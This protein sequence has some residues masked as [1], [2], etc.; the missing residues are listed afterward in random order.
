[1]SYE[2]W[3]WYFWLEM[4]QPGGDEPS[5]CGLGVSQ[6]LRSGISLPPGSYQHSFS[7]LPARK[8][9]S[10]WLES[11]TECCEVRA[12]RGTRQQFMVVS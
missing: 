4:M 2:L 11:G 7:P 6:C 5:C 8:H 1:M 12:G 9:T 3:G 10:H